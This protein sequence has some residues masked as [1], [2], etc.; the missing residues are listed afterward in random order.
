MMQE[1]KI[2][3]IAHV[4]FLDMIR[5]LIAQTGAAATKG[6]LIRNTLSVAEKFELVDFKSFDDF[7]T[8]IENVQN[9]ITAIEGKAAHKGNGLFGLPKC[10]FAISIANYNEVFKGM[11]AGYGELT[12]EYNKRG[13]VTNKYRVGHGAGVSPFCALHQPLRS[14]LEAKITIGGKP[15]VIYQLGCRAGSG[16]KGLA[17]KWI[18][19]AGDSVDE[20]S[21][22]LDDNM[23]CYAVKIQ[24]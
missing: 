10:P 14:A 7:V 22:V 9:P 4:S 19:E 5:V 12:E 17:S 1:G 8:S 3:D 21:K 23:C 24:K 6:T 15:T 20:V 11:P 13:G 18:E 16:A 2:L